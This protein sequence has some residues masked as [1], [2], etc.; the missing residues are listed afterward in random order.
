MVA[1]DLSGSSCHAYVQLA[2]LSVLG[3]A[4]VG[5]IAIESRSRRYEQQI[6]KRVEE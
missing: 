3:M 2:I 1:V 5:C 4:Y 6:V